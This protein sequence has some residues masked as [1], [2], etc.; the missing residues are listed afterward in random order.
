MNHGSNVIGTIQ[1]VKEVGK[2]C[3]DAGIPFAVDASQTAGMVP[4]DMQELNIDIL[5]FTGHKSLFGPT[6]IGGMYVREGI[7]IEPTRFGGTGV[8][9]AVR[10]HLYEYP[11]RLECGTA[12]LMGIAGLYAGNKFISDVGL[13]NIHEKEMGFYKRFR[14][15]LK[16]IDGITLYCADYDEKHLPILSMNL[17][18]FSAFDTGVMLDVDYSIA[19]R[20]GLHCAP[21]VHEGLGTAPKGTVRFSFG[22]FNTDEHVDH[23]VNAIEE[24]VEF[25]NKQ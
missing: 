3:R 20:T 4:V 24:I 14:D 2:I 7:E 21:L 17:N 25:C 23:A 18:K 19:T 12:N 1:P 11:Y 9:S 13:E 22:Y 16:N 8:K 5:A 15:R 10:T 6:G